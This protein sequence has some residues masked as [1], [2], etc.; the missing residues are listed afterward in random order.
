MRKEFVEIVC[1]LM[2]VFETQSE[3]IEFYQRDFVAP[4]RL[5]CV[6]RWL[7]SECQHYF[8]FYST[9]EGPLYVFYVQVDVLSQSKSI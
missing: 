8:T 9:K 4:P 6:R 2:E 5:I 7:N 1:H 3:K